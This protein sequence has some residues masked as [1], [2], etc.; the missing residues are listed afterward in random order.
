ME[1]DYLEGRYRACLDRAARAESAGQRIQHEEM[2]RF[3][4]DWIGEERKKQGV[5]PS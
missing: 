4:A 3:Y 2:A 1:L 5:Q